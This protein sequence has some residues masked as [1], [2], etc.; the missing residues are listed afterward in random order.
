VR[1]GAAGG[2]STGA[3]AVYAARFCCGGPA[4]TAVAAAAPMPVKLRIV[5]WPDATE[6][7]RDPTWRPHVQ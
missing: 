6:R 5:T 3:A 1:I 7:D 2:L 4:R